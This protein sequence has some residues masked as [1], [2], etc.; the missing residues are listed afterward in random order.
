M[1]GS[2]PFRALILAFVIPFGA[3]ADPIFENGFEDCGAIATRAC[4]TG[5]SAGAPALDF[6]GDTRPQ[7]PAFDIGRDEFVP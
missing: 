7:G 2:I 5:T 4:Y 6:E 1:H 3:A